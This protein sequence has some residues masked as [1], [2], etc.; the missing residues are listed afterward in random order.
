[1]LQLSPDRPAPEVK[2]ALKG[3]AQSVAGIVRA[4][5]AEVLHLSEIDD[6]RSFMDY[7]LDS[8]AGMLLSVRLEKRLKREVPP[9]SLIN[10][11]TVA[12]LTQHLLL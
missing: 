8:I 12:A 5:M 10:F 2:P 4:T 3:D 6:E 1:M 11:P 7:G 9:Q